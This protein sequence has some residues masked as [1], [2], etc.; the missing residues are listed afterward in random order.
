MAGILI[1][2][3]LNDFNVLLKV[4]WTHLSDATTAISKILL[5]NNQMNITN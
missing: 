2:I 1:N 5:L 3:F 4:T